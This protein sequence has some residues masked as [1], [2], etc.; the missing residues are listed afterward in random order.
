MNLFTASA[1]N[2]IQ[3]NYIGTDITGLAPLGNTANGIVLGN[4]TF[5]GGPTPP[6]SPNAVIIGGTTAGAR[7]IISNC[8]QNGIFLGTQNLLVQ[9]NYIGTDVN[10]TADMGNGSL[11]IRVEGSNDTLGGIAP[12]AGN[13]IAFSG[14]NERGTPSRKAI[15]GS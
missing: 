7:N 9:G 8:G 2:L 12:G 15:A 4:P 14:K 11:G 5:G 10:G 6:T 1:G 13:I 3:G